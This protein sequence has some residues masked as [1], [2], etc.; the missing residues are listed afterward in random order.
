MPP[1]ATERLGD[2]AAPA[3]PVGALPAGFAPELRGGVDGVELE[4]L[5]TA[6]ESFALVPFALAPLKLAG[7]DGD[8]LRLGA[9]AAGGFAS[10]DFASGA[11]ELDERGWRGGADFLVAIEF[12]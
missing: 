12:Y 6:P 4:L 11:L 9:F 5:L 3:L 10:G 1:R 2:L 8:G 7:F